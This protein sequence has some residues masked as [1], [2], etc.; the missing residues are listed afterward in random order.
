[1]H[2][3]TGEKSKHFS[4]P[5]YFTYPVSQHG[6]LGH[7]CPDNRGCTVVR[8]SVVPLRNAH[9]LLSTLTNIAC[10]LEVK[11]FTYSCHR[12]QYR[13]VRYIYT[14]FSLLHLIVMIHDLF[15]V[16]GV[17][18]WQMLILIVLITGFAVLLLFLESAIPHLRGSVTPERDQEHPSGKTVRAPSGHAICACIIIHY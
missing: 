6:R 4:Y 8:R 11:M 2:I 12:V 13:G 1:M 16:Q 18:D 17:K 10:G 9:K 14:M 3:E 15:L 7:R 5:D